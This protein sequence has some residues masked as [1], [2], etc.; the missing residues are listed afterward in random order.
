MVSIEIDQ[1]VWEY[2]QNHGKPFVDT[3][4][5]VIRRE[6]GLRK[7]KGRQKAHF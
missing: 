5:N 6:L 3:P 4:N 1:E 2:L 7:Q